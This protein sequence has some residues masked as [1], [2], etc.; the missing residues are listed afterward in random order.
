MQLNDIKTDWT[1][2]TFVTGADVHITLKEARF[3]FLALPAIQEK[4]AKVARTINDANSDFVN[5]AHEELASVDHL[6]HKIKLVLEPAINPLVIPEMDI[7]SFDP[8]EVEENVK[9]K[10]HKP[11]TFE[12]TV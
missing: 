7:F 1:R 9:S 6:I 8:T 3:L 11:I 5:P 2:G 4:L 12:D 10:K